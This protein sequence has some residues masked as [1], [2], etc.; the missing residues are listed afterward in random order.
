MVFLERATWMQCLLFIH[1]A[2]V[3]YIGLQLLRAASLFIPV[4]K[5]KSCAPNPMQGA[6]RSASATKSRFAVCTTDMRHTVLCPPRAASALQPLRTRDLSALSVK[7]ALRSQQDVKVGFEDLH[8]RCVEYS[9][10]RLYAASIRDPH[11]ND[12]LASIQS[13]AQSIGRRR[14]NQVRQVRRNDTVYQT[15]DVSTPLVPPLL[16]NA[17]SR[18]QKEAAGRPGDQVVIDVRPPSS[19]AVTRFMALLSEDVDSND[20][21][22][23]AIFPRNIF[24]ACSPSN[25]T[26]YVHSPAGLPQLLK[27]CARQASRSTSPMFYVRKL[28]RTPETC[29]DRTEA[30]ESKQKAA[31]VTAVIAS[32]KSSPLVVD[33]EAAL[34]AE[35]AEAPSTGPTKATEKARRRITEVRQQLMRK[36]ISK[37]EKTA[38]VVP[39][40]ASE[41]AVDVNVLQAHRQGVVRPMYNV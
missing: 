24:G 6:P 7:T 33:A 4:V 38:T 41:S 35:K 34:R 22:V 9:S 12:T 13:R 28:Q 5:D 30:G 37:N 11:S 36:N 21:G 31:V 39:L 40:N 19:S 17:S 14:Y 23:E 27:S 2:A 26:R 8:H 3:V 1:C 29:E 32:C 18:Q 20:E 15:L 10:V 16:T 25:D